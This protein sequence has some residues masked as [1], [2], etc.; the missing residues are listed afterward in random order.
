MIGRK[1]SSGT[2]GKKLKDRK[3]ISTN[4]FAKKMGV[5]FNAVRS[6][7]EKGYLDEALYPDGSLNEDIATK[8][9]LQISSVDAIAKAKRANPNLITTDS[10]IDQELDQNTISS[11]NLKKKLID[12]ALAKVELTEKQRTT[13]K[14]A[15]VRK[16]ARS[17]ARSHRDA[18]LAFPARYG[19]EIAAEVSIDPAIL[20]PVLEKFVRSSLTEALNIP[21]PFLDRENEED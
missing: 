3:G 17:F 4:A 5:H 7:V 18:A 6:R 1:K 10:V 15:D 21:E 19:A 16:A 8:V 14:L 20:I 12:I 2:T 11:A 9:W 13:V